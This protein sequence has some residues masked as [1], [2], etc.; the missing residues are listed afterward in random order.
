MLSKII[1]SYF[2]SA[3][4]FVTYL[5]AVPPFVEIVEDSN[6]DKI[7]NDNENSDKV[8]IKITLNSE[9]V[10]GNTIKATDN[11]G[12]EKLVTLSSKDVDNNYINIE[13]PQPENGEN[14]E[15]EVI[16]VNQLNQSNTIGNVSATIDVTNT[17]NTTS[18]SSQNTTVAVAPMATPTY[19]GSANLPSTQTVTKI[20]RDKNWCEEREFKVYNMQ[21]SN[22]KYVKG[23]YYLSHDKYTFNDAIEAAKN[24]FKASM[25]VP[26]NGAHNQWLANTFGLAWIGIYDPNHS[27][28]FGVVDE[29]RF[30]SVQHS[31]VTYANWYKDANDPSLDQPS[32]NIFDSDTGNVKILGEHYAYISP[33]G[34]WGV[35]GE[36]YKNSDSLPRLK[37]ILY[38]GTKKPTC[39]SHDENDT[40]DIDTIPLSCST[41]AV[42]DGSTHNGTVDVDAFGSTSTEWTQGGDIKACLTDSRGID[43][44]PAGNISCKQSYEYSNGTVTVNKNVVPTTYTYSCPD[45]KNIQGFNWTFNSSQCDNNEDVCTLTQQKSN[46]CKR[47]KYMCPKAKE[48]YC[49]NINGTWGCSA[50]PCFS[51]Q[52]ATTFTSTKSKETNRGFD[53]NGS[54]AGEISIFSGESKECR[55]KDKFWGLMGGGCCKRN[56][57]GGLGGMFG[58]ICKDDEKVLSTARRINKDKTKYMGEYCSKKIDLGFTRICVRWNHVYCIF[59]SDLAREIHEG[60][61]EQ[62]KSFTEAPGGTWGSTRHP[63][64]RGFTPEEFQKLDFSKIDLSE[65]TNK[66]KSKTNAEFQSNYIENY[67]N[68]QSTEV[69]NMN[70]Q[71]QQQNNTDKA[72]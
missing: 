36:H 13:F 46:M 67:Y 31:T 41:T 37:I 18:T 43:Y 28:N 62:L 68:Q 7:I 51:E 15:I 22:G 49:A 69:N 72:F 24:K 25:V 61:R 40:I 71:Q 38:F 60:G 6:S 34:Y 27:Q 17:Q 11:Y 12:H 59:S 64:C 26:M 8:T 63:N 9:G 30:M 52:D 1:K 19:N 44:C 56:K 55:Y 3:F 32:N 21:L 35:K 14:I 47:E 16:S 50:S 54:C 45:D 57:P 10:D 53:D 42:N 5:Y 65:Y 20:D 58:Q 66:L 48:R 4:I 2:L 70:S 39:Y 23:Y 29:S 33:S